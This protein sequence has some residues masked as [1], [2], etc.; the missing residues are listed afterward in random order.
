MSRTWLAF[1]LTV[2]G[3]ILGIVARKRRW[4]FWKVLVGFLA[5]MACVH[6]GYS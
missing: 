2:T 4:P 6:W 3:L 5:V 1:T